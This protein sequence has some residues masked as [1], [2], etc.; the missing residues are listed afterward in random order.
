MNKSDTKQSLITKPF[1]KSSASSDSD[2]TLPASSDQNPNWNSGFPAPYGLP[3][4]S[5]GKYVKRTE[6]NHILRVLSNLLFNAQNGSLNM[7][8]SAV[9]S[10]LGGYPKD[11]TVWYNYDNSLIMIRSTIENNS[12]EPVSGSTVN[13][14]L[15]GGN[16][17]VWAKVD[18]GLLSKNGGTLA[19]DAVTFTKGGT[20]STLIFAGGTNATAGKMTLKGQSEASLSAGDG[21]NRAD[22]IVNGGTAKVKIGTANPKNIVTSVLG[23]AADNSGNV[24]LTGIVKSVEGQTPNA[25]GAVTIPSMV[26]KVNGTSPNS[27][28]NVVLTDIVKKVNNALPDANGNVQ[29]TIPSDYVKKVNNTAPDSSGNVALTLPKPLGIGGWESDSNYNVVK[30]NNC[31][32]DTAYDIPAGCYVLAM[33]NV[34][35]DSATEMQIKLSGASDWTRIAGQGVDGADA[36][37]IFCFSAP[38]YAKMQIRFHQLRRGFGSAWIIYWVPKN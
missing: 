1:D 38:V 15:T 34:P 10:A 13:I 23:V 31:T 25:Q 4:E 24:P 28:G 19:N 2:W 21:T 29:I 9:A 36:N 16:S 37:P 26:K 7:W 8:S 18:L 30:Y 27:S 20:S 22:V 17:K 3:L 5:G 6:M 11:A 32:Q 14:D 35:W 33:L 12:T